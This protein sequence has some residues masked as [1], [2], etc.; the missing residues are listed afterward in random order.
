MTN[1]EKFEEVFG[2]KPYTNCCPTTECGE[3]PANNW[4]GFDCASMWWNSEY[5]ER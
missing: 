3:C 4:G 1:A 5:K 2:V